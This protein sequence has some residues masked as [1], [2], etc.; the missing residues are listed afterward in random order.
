MGSLTFSS[1]A[2]FLADS[3]NAFRVQLGSGNNRILQPAYDVFTQD[4]FKWT[5]NFTVNIGLRYAW[6]ATPSEVV[7]RFTNFDPTTGTLVSASQPYQQNNKN[8]Q[9]RIGFAWDPFKNGK[10]S[11]RGAY[12]I[13]TQSPTTNIVTGVSGNPPF[14]LPISASSAT[15]NITI[16]NPSAAVKGTSIGPAA[17]NPG[18]N[19][20]YAQ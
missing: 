4:S 12:A 10:T 17:I 16:E 18:F 9:P 11:V 13:L 5:T 2:N 14:P 20:M 3:A 1:L 6:N 8:F 7:G 15:N 19:N